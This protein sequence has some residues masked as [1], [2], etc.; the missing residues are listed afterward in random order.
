MFQHAAAELNDGVFV[1]ELADPTEGLDENVG[2]KGGCKMIG[3]HC[4]ESLDL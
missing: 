4:G 1:S 3:R 2:L